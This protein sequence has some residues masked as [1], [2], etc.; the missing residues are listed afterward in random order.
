MGSF[1]I[2]HWI[3]VALVVLLVFGTKKL[4]GAGR[5]LGE[6]IKGFKQG[7]RDEDTP[8]AQ[9]EQRRTE[10]VADGDRKRDRDDAAR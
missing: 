2:W 7:M 4:R 9:I 6:A 5:D 10:T 3:I 1:S 8:S